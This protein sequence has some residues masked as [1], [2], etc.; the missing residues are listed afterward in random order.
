[1]TSTAPREADDWLAVTEAELPVAEVMAWA[2]APSCG[3]VVTF[4]GTVRDHA[5][6]RDGVI[7]LE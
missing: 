3:A 2:T 6:G 4:S 5:P 7:S 1:V